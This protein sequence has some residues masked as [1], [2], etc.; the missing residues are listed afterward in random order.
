M[1]ASLKYKTLLVDA[2]YLAYRVYFALSGMVS[3]Q[4][5][6]HMVHGFFTS[7][8]A[9]L[10]RFLVEELVV[11]LD[12]G[13]DTKSQLYMGYKKKDDI[14]SPEQRVDFIAQF[15][16]LDNFLLWLGVRCCFQPGF[17]ADDVIAHLCH[18]GKARK[19]GDVEYSAKSPILI[20]SGDRDLYPLLSENVS[21]WKMRKESLYTMETFKEEFPG[22]VPK[23][24]QDMQAFM[25]C[26]GDKVPGVRGIGPKRAMELV[27]KYGTAM[28]VKD[29]SEKDRFVKLV[30]E[31]W[32]VVMLSI[33]L[34]MFERVDPIIIT[35]EPDLSRLRKHLFML[36]MDSLIEDWVSI[37]ALSRL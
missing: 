4:V 16:L 20:L 23:Q 10:K 11:V 5:D 35:E 31:N 37:E 14:M 12:G 28:K 6:T 3:G 24:Y 25:G 19:A 34:T 18:G 8:I 15:K 30:Q 13:H 36:G 21:M 1:V 27:R 22:L 9:I 7:L 32:D 17:E 2:S 29:A 26:S 33:K